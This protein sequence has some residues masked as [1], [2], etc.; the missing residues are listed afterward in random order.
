MVLIR[1]TYE[2]V[3]KPKL[4]D[5][6]ALL[7]DYELLHDY[8]VLSTMEEYSSYS[9]PRYFW[10]RSGR[11]IAIEE[12]MQI[13][14]I[15][16]GSPL[17]LIPVIA[18]WVAVKIVHPLVQISGEIADWSPNRRKAKAEAV[19][20]E[21]EVIEKLSDIEYKQMRNRQRELL[22]EQEEYRTEM[23][24]MTLEELKRQREF[25]QKTTLRRLQRRL[26]ENPY[27]LE[28]ITIESEE[29]QADQ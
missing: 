29:G 7:Y 6:S 5:L 3:T 27:Q 23:T 25:G 15:H 22:L 13:R 18:S 12:R 4:S 20:A 17:L 11:P 8:L 14:K 1:L 9:F 21:L 19:K 28:D 24:E 16:Y 10:Y 2:A 26:S